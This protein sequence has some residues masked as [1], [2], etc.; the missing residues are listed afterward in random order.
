[1][2]SVSL[3]WFL[4]SLAIVGGQYEQCEMMLSVCVWWWGGVF[5]RI[6]HLYVGAPAAFSKSEILGV[7]LGE[8]AYRKMSLPSCC[9]L[10]GRITS[11]KPQI[12]ATTHVYM[13]YV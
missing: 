7:N 13:H 8:E 10:H 5:P 6:P 2:I 3:V 1:M 11:T 4:F 9:Y 12:S